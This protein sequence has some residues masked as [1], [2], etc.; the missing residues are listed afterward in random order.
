MT[1]DERRAESASKL[2]GA[3]AEILTDTGFVNWLKAS[4]NFRNYSINNQI[5]IAC[6]RPSA[7]VVQGY[8]NKAGTSGWKSVGRH[9]LKGEAAIKIF[10]PMFRKEEN[11]DGTTS[12]KIYGFRLVPVFDISQTDGEAFG[13]PD[14]MGGET[15]S[16][17]SAE[18]YTRLV[19]IAEIKGY[20][21]S[22]KDTGSAGGWMNPDTKEIAI[23]ADKAN[24]EMVSTLVHELCHA[25]DPE[26]SLAAYQT[27]RD[28]FE[29][30]AQAA[31]FIILDGLGVEATTPSA[32]YVAHW[33]AGDAKKVT[34]MLGRITKIAAE[35][36][37]E[38]LG[39]EAAALV[40]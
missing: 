33:A 31:A 24:V 11:D 21:V 20:T 5:M 8:G 15:F 32:A 28:D 37:G 4:R 29:V 2:E 10:A 34:A 3:I 25:F 23:S 40:S 13:G 18:L 17:D 1:A 19:R 12:K 9:V 39:S 22:V 35:I 38:L 36:E 6:Q 26:L 14:A 27:H 7:T 30:V 16:G